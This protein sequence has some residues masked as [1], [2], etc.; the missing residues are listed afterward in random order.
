MFLPVALGFWKQH[1]LW[2]GTY[3]LDDLLDIVELIRV[4]NE[5][6]SRAREAQE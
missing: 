6:H 1:E 2:D 3:T 4:R 5:N